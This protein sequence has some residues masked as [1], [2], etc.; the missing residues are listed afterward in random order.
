MTAHSNSVSRFARFALVAALG[1]IAVAG[2]VWANGSG[3][4]PRI[5]GE[6]PRIA[7]AA[8]HAGLDV[9][10]LLTTYVDHPF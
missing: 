3:S 10:G 5:T 9:A 8:V 1:I 7:I 6:T 4:Q 2:S